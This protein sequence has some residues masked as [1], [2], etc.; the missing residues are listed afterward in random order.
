[1]KTYC[2]IILLSVSCWSFSFAQTD[3]SKQRPAEMRNAEI[4]PLQTSSG[5]KSASGISCN[6]NIFWA[7]RGT[8]Q[9]DELSINGS[10]VTITG[11]ALATGN[12]N[13][14]AYCF[15]LSGGSFSPTFYS[16]S[17]SKQPRYFD[18]NTWINT[19]VNVSPDKIYNC[20]GNGNY[21]YYLLYDSLNTSKGITRYNG[22]GMI[23]VVTWGSSRR[24]SVADLAVDASGNAWFFT[25]PVQS[26]SNIIT[27][28]LHVISP[29]GQMVAEFAINLNTSGAYG[30][31]LLNGTLYIALGAN[32]PTNPNS[33]QPVS[34]SGSTAT[35]GVPIQM[36]LPVSP[37]SDLESCNPGSPLSL[38][39]LPGEISFYTYPNPVKEELNI[40]FPGSNG[41]EFFIRIHD[42]LGK[43]VVTSRNKLQPGKEEVTLNIRDL[44]PGNY[45]IQ[46]QSGDKMYNSKFVKN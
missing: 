32:H 27:D 10:A 42:A 30:L 5:L 38:S 12:E 45:F 40:F 36:P 39:D 1:M 6:S 28:S 16:V 37:Y 11:M 31:M 46:I 13:N 8:G 34:V 20:G 44:S 15:N 22:T 25:G 4:S 23:N 21:L 18:G 24:A 14:L 7:I 41:A 33:L 9:V 19:P 35:A 43:S 26:G 17:L 2:L 3:L 29:G